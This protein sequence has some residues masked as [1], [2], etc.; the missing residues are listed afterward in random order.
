MYY[1]S[2]LFLLVVYAIKSRLVFS[3][4]IYQ[5]EILTEMFFLAIS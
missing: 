2:C 5:Y 4:H 1:C 3:L